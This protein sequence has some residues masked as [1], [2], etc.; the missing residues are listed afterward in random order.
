MTVKD[1]V[2]KYLEENGFDG[3]FTDDCGC[4]KGNLAPFCDTMMNCQPG[5]A[6]DCP[7]TDS[8]GDGYG[9][10]WLFTHI[11]PQPPE[12]TPCKVCGGTGKDP[13]SGP[14]EPMDDSCEH[15]NGSGKENSSNG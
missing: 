1:I 11:G 3:L 15:C 2:K 9:C 5:Y 10:D 4:A 6:I 14:Y 7:G 13:C 8:C 12:Q